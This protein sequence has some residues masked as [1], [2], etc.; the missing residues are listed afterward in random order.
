MVLAALATTDEQLRAAPY[1]VLQD[2]N[3]YYAG[4]LLI[5]LPDAFGTAAF[6]RDAP[7]WVAELDRLPPRQ[8]AADRSGRDDHRVVEA[9]GQGP[10]REAADLF[11]RARRRCDHRDLQA[12]RGPGAHGLRLGH[13][14]HQRLRGLRAAAD[15]RPQGDLAGLQGER[16]QRPPGGQA[17]GQPAEG[18]RRSR[19]RSRATSRSSATRAWSSTR[20]WCDRAGPPASRCC[21]PRAPRLSP[22]G[23]GRPRLRGFDAVEFW[24]HSNKD[25]ACHP[26][27]ARRD[28]PAARRHPLRADLQPHRSASS[29]HGSSRAWRGRATRR[30]R[31][32]PSC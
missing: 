7:D 23:S 14:P 27:G 21:S 19:R 9:K 11:R 6:L 4:N 12:L 17:L 32:A 15:R 29:M 30:W 10:A 1:Q 13:Q 31:S 16:R 20:C 5:V 24:R 2:W 25:L 8:R 28:R 18:D 3:H 26:R 22:I